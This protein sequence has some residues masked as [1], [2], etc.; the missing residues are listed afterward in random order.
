MAQKNIVQDGIV[1]YSTSD[2]ALSVDFSILGQANVSKQLNVG[3]DPLASG[4]ITTQASQD[5]I[6][7]TGAGGNLRLIPS[8]GGL[9]TIN[10]ISWPT[11]TATIGTFLGVSAS[12]TLAFLPAGTPIVPTTRVAFGSATNQL[13]TDASLTYN[14]STDTLSI[15][16]AGAAEISAAAGEPLLLNSDVSITLQT[17][18]NPV[19]ELG[20]TGSFII[21]GTAGTSGQLLVSNGTGSTPTWQSVP[22]ASLTWTQVAFGSASNTITSDPGLSYIVGT[23]TLSIGGSGAGVVAAD[24]GQSLILKSDTSV[25]INTN[26]LNRLSIDASGAY[27]VNGIVGT[28]GQVLTSAGASAP[29]TW[30]TPASS[31]PTLTSTQIAYGSGSNLLTSD[32]TLTYDISTTTLSIG[33]TGGGLITSNPAQSLTVASDISITFNTNSIPRLMLNTNGSFN[34]AGSTGSSGQALISNGSTSSPT[35][36]ATVSPAPATSIGASGDF[37]GKIAFDSSYFYVCTAA[38]DG[39]TAIWVRTALTTF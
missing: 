31:V 16:A 11:N 20:T 28:A 4:L 10:N 21:N 19:L 18:G 7:Q 29:A 37:A 27:N 39:V 2:P 24:P 17:N 14:V 22:S 5:L 13:T 12:N 32:P 8:T 34:I 9:I 23:S 1:V 33:G 3:D 35:W 15:G 25:S 30:T 38:Y 36:Q 6:I 26:S